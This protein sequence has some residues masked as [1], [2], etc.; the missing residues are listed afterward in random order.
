MSTAPIVAEPVADRARRRITRRILPYLFILFIVAFLDR[1][2]VSYAALEMTKDLN[3]SPEVYGFGAGIFFAGYFLLEIPG[4]I[5]V[6]RWSARAWIARIMISWGIVAILTAF[7]Q[8]A[9]QFYWVRFFLGAAEAGF[10]PG[11][12]VYLGHWFRYA[13]RA[14]ALA[15]F[16]AAL[17]VSNMIGSPISGLLLGINWL[18]LQGWRWLFILEGIPAVVLGVITLAYLTDWPHQAKWMPH[19]ER[20]WI[21]SELEREKRAKQKAHPSGVWRTLSDQRV[22][23]LSLAYFFMVASVYGFT[24]WLPTIVKKL[25]GFSNL[26][27]SLL[28]ALPYCMGLGATL[29]A[30]W[31]SD[32][33]GERR[34][35][36]ACPM[37]VAGIALALGVVSQNTPLVTISM[38]SLA[39][40][41]IY[42]YLPGFWSL[43]ANFLTGTVA[44]ASIGLIN[45]IGNLG[46]FAGPYIVGYLNRSTHSFSAGIIYLSLSAVIAAGLVLTLRSGEQEP[47]TSQSST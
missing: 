9:R 35:H 6:E 24:F 25:S 27:V 30:G 19:D 22:V 47:M 14:K 33:T 31:S 11:I 21:T 7:V 37:I 1:V 42:G 8:T 26:A 45:S 39:A 18:H 20:Q 16:L 34:W 13:D 28:A 15:L 4:A 36:T 32:R 40:A 3:F 10:F 38:F 29:F 5:L 46:G 41:G 44:A 23:V 43:P 2:N 12:I 17:P